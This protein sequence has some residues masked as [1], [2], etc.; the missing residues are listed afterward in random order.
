MN[1]EKEN[2]RIKDISKDNR[3]RERLDSEGAQA[4][5]DAELLA[6]LLRVGVEG[7]NA[8]DLG[9]LILQKFGSLINIQ[10]ASISEL[11]RINGIGKAKAIQIKAAVELGNRISREQLFERKAIRKP[12]DAVD[13]VKYELRG[14]EQEELWVV[15]LDTRNNFIGIDKLYKGSLNSSSIRIGELFK[16][17]IRNSAKSIIIFHNHPSMDPTESSEDISVTRAA[18]EA[19][20]LIDID[21]LDHIIIAGNEHCSIRRKHQDLWLA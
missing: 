16:T 1:S 5:S 12:E 11:C 7:L 20:K 10:R 2:I 4:L 8:V 19:G 13:L 14:K 6:I 3:P 18:I 17:A 21:V 9:H 15:L